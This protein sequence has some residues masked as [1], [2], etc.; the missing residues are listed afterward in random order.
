VPPFLLLAHCMPKARRKKE[1][2]ASS[3]PLPLISGLGDAT[4]EFGLLRS[5][6][7]LEEEPLLALDKEGEIPHQDEPAHSV[8]YMEDD[9]EADGQT[10]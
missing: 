4:S 1:A 3:V 2:R 9:D 8:P 7:E 10:P 6:E 5:I